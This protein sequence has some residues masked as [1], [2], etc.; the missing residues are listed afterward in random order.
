MAT[1]EAPLHKLTDWLDF[2]STDWQTDKRPE[3]WFDETPGRI[4]RLASE[5]GI[6]RLASHVFIVAGTNGKGTTCTALAEFAALQG[7]SVGLLTSPHLHSFNERIRVNGEPVNDTELVAA[8]NRI[9]EVV[10]AT[11]WAHPGL[12]QF[13]YVTLAAAWLFH[14]AGVDVAIMEV[15]LG[16][17]LDPVNGFDPTVSIITRVALDHERW[18]GADRESIGA[19][20]AGIQRPGIPCIVGEKN[21]PRTVVAGAKEKGTPL[22]IRGR[23]FHENRIGPAA[24]QLAT[25]NVHT[26]GL[27]HDSLITAAQAWLAAGLE[28]TQDDLNHVAQTTME[29]R[30]QLVRS[31][32]RHFILDI[33]HNPDAVRY[34]GEVVRQRQGELGSPRVF[35]LFAVQVDKDARAMLMEASS[36]VDQLLICVPDETSRAA[37]DIERL[38]VCAERTGWVSGRYAKVAEAC[39]AVLTQSEPDD[40][41]VVFGSVTLVAQTLN[42]LVPD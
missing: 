12:T 16:G 41:I 17:R 36:W 30:C 31:R 18:L 42:E 23:D 3:S 40:L 8:F 32:H 33:A 28:L 5:L 9:R 11:Q 25:N 26:G 37:E 1:P 6:S 7:R 21:P 27:P 19:E 13:D 34:L 29:G 24:L 14:H 39:Q 22:T 35:G 10:I 2:L 4:A 15:G 20:K 38:A